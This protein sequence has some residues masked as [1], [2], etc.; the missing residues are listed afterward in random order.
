MSAPTSSAVRLLTDR[1][2]VAITG[3]CLLV[4]ADGAVYYQRTNVRDTANRAVQQTGRLLSLLASADQQAA[5][6][7]VATPALRDA[8]EQLDGALTDKTTL[9]ERHP[10]RVRITLLLE[11]ARVARESTSHAR[12]LVRAARHGIDAELLELVAQAEWHVRE[13]EAAGLAELDQIGIAVMVLQ[14]AALGLLVYLVLRPGLAKVRQELKA[15]QL[16]QTVANVANAATAPREAFQRALEEVCAYT[17]WSAGSVHV[18]DV[19]AER[20]DE[21]SV[22][23]R[24]DPTDPLD[25]LHRIIRS[26]R[27]QAGQGMLGKALKSGEPVH[28]A[29][30][31]DHQ[32]WGSVARRLGFDSAIA[33]PVMVRED[34]R[35]LLLFFGSPLAEP[36]PATMDV[37]KHIALLLGRVMERQGAQKANARLAAVVEASPDAVS[38][39]ALDGRIVTWNPGAEQLFG[40]SPDE[41]E[42]GSL[43]RLIQR[44]RDL[45]IEVL[46]LLGR[47]AADER[48][49][50]YEM[51]M[52][53]ADGADIIVSLTIAP[54]NDTAGDII[55]GAI[56]ARDITEKRR[57]EEKLAQYRT[58][59]KSTGDAILA[60]TRKGEV[61]SSNPGA[62]ALFGYSVDELLGVRLQALNRSDS[63]DEIAALLRR[64]GAG[65]HVANHETVCQRKD[66]TPIEVSLTLSPIRD[67]GGRVSGAAVIGRDIARQKHDER[68]LRRTVESLARSNAELEKFAYV[69]SHDLK[70]PLRAIDNLSRWIEEDLEAVLTA[71]TQEQMDLLR[72]RV[73]RMQQL[74]EGLLDYSRAGRLQAEPEDVDTAELVDEV[75]TLIGVPDGFTVEAVG[76]L[77]QLHTVRAPLRQVF[78]NL[79][80]NALKHHD[81]KSG[82][83]TVTAT[84]EGQYV[85]FDVSDD[86][87]G[88]EQRYHERVFEIF[89]TLKR[90]DEV[91]STGIGLAV[92]A[93][94]VESFGGEVSV[95]SEGRGTTF[96]V[97]WPK[98]VAR[99]SA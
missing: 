24:V 35:A 98:I 73:H 85:R 89:Q 36:D 61:I 70:A 81:Q 43:F 78:L 44:D 18:R 55:G 53:H 1:T 97:A 71:S 8:L 75:R 42:G 15:T 21:G 62:E 84:D 50:D 26:A 20:R 52:V 2:R 7:D 64:V 68:E 32:A 28:A 69:V 4:L 63:P 23:F 46:D 27:P 87:P 17:G 57:A 47:L 33:F 79:I 39:I 3:L 74:L 60:T 9:P 90:R 13:R 49:V 56:I 29:S 12:E 22:L 93:K 59:V 45:Q 72:G 77:P 11:D 48:V 31:P 40:Y 96:A 41:M 88:I 58:T 16:L 6:S 80:V 65:E 94:M 67:P 76:E 38:S 82:R 91:E 19:V 95:A 10:A 25:A 66:G 99:V 86:G 30:L 92:V 14:L 34:A 37:I 5:S 51:M 54:I 83:V